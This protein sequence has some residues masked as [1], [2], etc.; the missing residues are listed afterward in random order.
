LYAFF[1]I[2]PT[3]FPPGGRQNGI[4]PGITVKPQG[5]DGAAIGLYCATAKNGSSDFSLKQAK[6]LPHDRFS[7]KLAKR[8]QAGPKP[9]P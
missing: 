8:P 1:G 3:E 7:P 6:S 4:H 9:E 2:L 5:D